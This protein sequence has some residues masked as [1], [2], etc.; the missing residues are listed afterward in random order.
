MPNEVLSNLE[1]LIHP[2]GRELRASIDYFENHH[3]KTVSQVFLSGGSARCDLIVQA[4]QAE[5]MVPCQVW[6]PTKFLQMALPPEKLGE[7]EQAATQLS[8]ALGAATASFEF[9]PRRINLLGDA[10]AAE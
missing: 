6:S 4:L 10:Q 2:L 3:D 8:V 1:P 5:M 7:I 9:M